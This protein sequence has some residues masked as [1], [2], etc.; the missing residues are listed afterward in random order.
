MEPYFNTL[1]GEGLFPTNESDSVLQ[2]IWFKGPEAPSSLFKDGE[3]N[4]RIFHDSDDETFIVDDAS[5]AEC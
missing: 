3:E 4:V 2:P 1:P 5:D